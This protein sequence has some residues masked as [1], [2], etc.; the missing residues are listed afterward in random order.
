MS[1]MTYRE[2][3]RQNLSCSWRGAIRGGSWHRTCIDVTWDRP[4]NDADDTYSRGVQSYIPSTSC[5][6]HT[7][8][9]LHYW[10]NV[11]SRSLRPRARP[12]VAIN[13]ANMFL[14]C[15]KLDKQG[16]FSPRWSGG[17]HFVSQRARTWNPHG[18]LPPIG[19]L[20]FDES[21]QVRA[22]PFSNSLYSIVTVM[23]AA[24]V[25]LVRSFGS[26]SARSWS[27]FQTTLFLGQEPHP[28]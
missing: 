26:G 22:L 18:S 21:H 1:R 12:L 25:H 23:G 8:V 3:R 20:E 7:R 2:I 11:D 10:H 16:Q 5:L 4:S 6:W 28:F 14:C 24:A 9:S 27:S 19:P 15:S 13:H 17:I